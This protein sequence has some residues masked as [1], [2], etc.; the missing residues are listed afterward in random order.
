[1]VAN[2]IKYKDVMDL[3]FVEQFVED[4]VFFNQYGFQY[5]IITFEC[6]KRIFIDWDKTTRLCE[7]LR[8]DKD[9]NIKGRKKIESIDDLKEIILF[10]KL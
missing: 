9:G 3:G 1:M 10:Y 5:S 8:V 7:I 2:E 4:N 6:A